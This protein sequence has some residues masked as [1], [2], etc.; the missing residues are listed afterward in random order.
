MS[1]VI[2]WLNM[3]AQPSSGAKSLQFSMRL[4]HCPFFVWASS[5]GSEESVGF[6]CVCT[7]SP[8]SLL[9]ACTKILFEGPNMF[10]IIVHVTVESK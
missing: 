3:H 10:S 4:H 1:K 9:L 6:L 7:D 2:F 5:E 8:E